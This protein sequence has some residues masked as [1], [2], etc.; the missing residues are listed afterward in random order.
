MDQRTPLAYTGRAQE[1]FDTL[2][3][4]RQRR[5]RA[6]IFRLRPSVLGVAL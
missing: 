1:W 6:L 5:I 3:A 2:P 4:H